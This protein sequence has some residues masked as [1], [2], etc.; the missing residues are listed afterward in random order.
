MSAFS[1]FNFLLF[2]SSCPSLLRLLFPPPET[3][4]YVIYVCMY[5][6][7]I[8]NRFLPLYFLIEF[9][10]SSALK[11]SKIRLGFFFCNLKRTDTLD[12][13]DN[14]HRSLYAESKLLYSPIT[15]QSFPC[16]SIC[17]EIS[18]PGQIGPF[19]HGRSYAAR[20]RDAS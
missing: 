6:C 13:F 14:I 9:S 2:H 20:E 12:N 16:P 17:H 7:I 15:Q 8:S 11:F 10:F 1:F 5:V 4:I 18:L 19:V 3:Y